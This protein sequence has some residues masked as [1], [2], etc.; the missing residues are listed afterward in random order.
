MCGMPDNYSLWQGLEV[1]WSGYV[2]RIRTDHGGSDS[3]R[4]PDCGHII[5]II[6]AVEP[7]PIPRFYFHSSGFHAVVR[8]QT[9]LQNG[10]LT[11][12][13][14]S[15]ERRSRFLTDDELDE[16]FRR[17]IDVNNQRLN[18]GFSFVSKPKSAF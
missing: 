11:L 5:P 12:L 14:T 8:G 18:R 3:F 2:R 10:K 15:V 9:F 1:R 6:W 17:I 13:V 16:Q 7:Y 4:D